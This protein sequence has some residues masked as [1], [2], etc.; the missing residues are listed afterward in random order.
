MVEGMRSFIGFFLIVWSSGTLLAGFAEN[1]T[2][3]SGFALVTLVSGNVAGLVGTE[4]LRNRTTSGVEQAVMPP[5]PLV[6]TASIL[7]PVGAVGENTTAI[8]IANPSIASG[9]VNLIL[10][11]NI[12]TVVLNVVV[13]L[14]PRG[15]LAKYLNEFFATQAVA[16]STPLLLTVSSE[17]PVSIVAF[18]F[19]GEEFASIPLVSL[20]APIPV[21]VQPL[22]IETCSTPTTLP[23]AAN[24]FGL[25]VA[26]SPPCSIIGVQTV[27]PPSA[28]QPGFGLG[29]PPATPPTA[30]FFTPP[31]TVSNSPVPAVTSSTTTVINSQAPASASVGGTAALVFPQVVTGGTW[32]TDIVLGNTSAGTQSVRID[33]FSPDGFLT[34]SL[35]EIT[36]PPRG[37]FF[38][39]SEVSA[40]TGN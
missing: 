4:T 20:S 23:T 37:V 8:A 21:A 35:T 11:D 26:P 2:P 3:S 40:T 16:F 30:I 27:T 9:G 12:G 36:I 24:G 1:T 15:Q 10:T 17:I 7:V 33:F 34:G 28:V 5:S 13:Q 38:F 6:T 18:N 32:S 39:S 29:L 31:V 14:G 19:R 22:S 25:G